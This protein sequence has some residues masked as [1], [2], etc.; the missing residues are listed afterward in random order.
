MAIWSGVAL[1]Q[2]SDFSQYPHMAEGGKGAL[3][4]LS[5]GGIDLIHEGSALMT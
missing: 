5:Y 3:W 4:G 2:V 1:F